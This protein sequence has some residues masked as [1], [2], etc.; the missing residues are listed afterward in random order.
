MILPARREK[1]VAHSSG[2]T[3]R[4]GPPGHYRCVGIGAGPA[5]LSLASLLYSYPDMSNLFLE[6]KDDFGWH[7]GQQVPRASL[8]VSFCKDLVEPDI[9]RTLIARHVLTSD[10][11]SEATLREIL[12]AVLCGP[13][14]PGRPP[15]PGRRRPGPGRGGPGP[16][17][18]NDVW[19]RMP[20]VPPRISRARTRQTLLLHDRLPAGPPV[21]RPADPQNTPRPPPAARPADLGPV[22]TASP[23]LSPAG[24]Q[25]G[26]RRPLRATRGQI[27]A[28]AQKENN[29]MTA[30]GGPVRGDLSVTGLVTRARNGDQQAWDALVDRYAPLIWSIC[31]R[32]RLGGADAGDVGQSVWLQL[33]DQL[34]RIRDPA[35]LPGWLATTT[36]RECVRVLRAIRTA[37][38]SR[39]RAR[40]REHPGP[41]GQD[42]R[43]RAA[44]GRAPRRAARG[45]RAPAP[46]RPAADHPAH[47]GPAGAVRP[48]QRPAGHPGR[49]HRAEPPPLPGQAAPPSALA[50]LTDTETDTA[51]AMTA[52]TRSC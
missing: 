46:R 34:D 19:V 7:D 38:R 24:W 37:A 32:H 27:S 25:H 23:S 52:G 11:I 12:P 51:A 22:L 50:A 47:P 3:A 6:Q 33:V 45:V 39:A 40:R 8:Q 14:R 5:N 29:I 43:T 28:P 9:R 35:A 18:A 31:R 30:E 16:R 48:D 21:R 17:D 42:G 26:R 49:Q 2:S 36:R 1:A 15:G 10:G 41:A 4:V 13:R 20:P 44:G